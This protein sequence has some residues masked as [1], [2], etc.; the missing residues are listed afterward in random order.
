[1]FRMSFCPSPMEGISI[2]AC[3]HLALKMYPGCHPLYK[4]ELWGE[5]FDRLLGELFHKV[6]PHTYADAV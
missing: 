2:L 1:M 6:N 3:T 4:S 5:S